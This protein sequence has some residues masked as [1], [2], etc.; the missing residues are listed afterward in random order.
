METIATLHTYNTDLLSSWGIG[1][2]TKPISWT[3]ENVLKYA[4]NIK[5]KVIVKPSR[6]TF[7]YIKGINNNKKY[8]DIKNHLETNL[9]ARYKENS[10]TW[11]LSYF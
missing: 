1:Q 4:V 6:G 8:A 2:T 3:F 10:K 11:L 7:W 5:A 9:H